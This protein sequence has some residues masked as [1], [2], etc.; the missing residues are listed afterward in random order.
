MKLMRP[1]GQTGD[2]SPWDKK[3]SVSDLALK[4]HVKPV[5]DISELKGEFWPKDDDPDEFVRWL[6]RTRNEDRLAS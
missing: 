4:Q 2:V 6:R 5:G 3:M 1:P